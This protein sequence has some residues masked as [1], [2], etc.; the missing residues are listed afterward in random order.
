MISTRTEKALKK[1]MACGVEI[2][3]TFDVKSNGNHIIRFFNYDGDVIA[4]LTLRQIIG[5][6]YK[7]KTKKAKV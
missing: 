4:V 5:K 2:V 1:V 7:A 6:R 3:C